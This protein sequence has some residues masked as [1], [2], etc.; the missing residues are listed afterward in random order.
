M[1]DFI[2]LE[3]N[4]G[5]EYQPESLANSLSREDLSRVFMSVSAC[6]DWDQVSVNVPTT[7]GPDCYRQMLEDILKK[8]LDNLDEESTWT[9]SALSQPHLLHNE[10]ATARMADIPYSLSDYYAG[11]DGQMDCVCCENDCQSDNCT[12][13]VSPCDMCESSEEEDNEY[14]GDENEEDEED[15]EDAEEIGDL[16]NGEVSELQI[17]V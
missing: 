13:N 10:T 3:D 17:I 7:F 4:S 5:S 8:H 1:A 14:D 11:S 12:E 6:T 16:E 9:A 2:P 15:E